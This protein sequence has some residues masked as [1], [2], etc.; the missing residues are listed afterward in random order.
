MSAH[1]MQAAMP[2]FQV[3][4]RPRWRYP[5]CPHQRNCCCSACICATLLDWS[6][7]H[8][9]ANPSRCAVW[10]VAAWR[11]IRHTAFCSKY[12]LPSSTQIG[13]KIQHPQGMQEL[14]AAQH[15]QCRVRGGCAV[16]QCVSVPCCNSLRAQLRQGTFCTSICTAGVCFTPLGRA[17]L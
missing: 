9:N 2:G 16:P 17:V 3:V 6:R 1:S 7:E 10:A 4:W 13:A 15:M 11:A 12:P 14:L 5:R 8:Y